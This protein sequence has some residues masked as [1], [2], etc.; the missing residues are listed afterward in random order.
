MIN[1]Q[2]KIENYICMYDIL[3]REGWSYLYE[4]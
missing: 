2:E 3:D 4:V 1:N